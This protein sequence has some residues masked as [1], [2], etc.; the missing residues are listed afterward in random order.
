MSHN[1][2]I[3]FIG[4]GHMGG[5]QVRELIKLPIDVA[6]YDVSPAAMAVFADRAIV[7]TSMADTGRDAD[8]VGI[9]VRDDAQ[10]M[11]CVRELLPVMKAR[12]VIL[13]HSTIR[14]ET[15]A[16]IAEQAAERGVDVLDA[17][18]TRTESAQDGPFVFCMTGGDPD[19]AAGLQDI[20]DAFSTD[21]IHVGP[22]GSAMALKICNNIASWSEILL[23]L[24]V[25][26]IAAKANV[27]IDKLLTV[28]SR[29]GVLSPPMR[30]AIELRNAPRSAKLQESCV[31]L[32]GLGEKDLSL[33]EQLSADGGVQA[34]ITTFMRSIVRSNIL[35]I[36]Q[37]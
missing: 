5:D 35:A 32:G 12:A 22:L 33:G 6:I 11:E 16:I 26:A 15:M 2:K 10:V 19:V 1:R 34:P 3:G 27:P 4:L 7:A 29:N 9:C 14:P 30:S 37:D 18:V 20:L 24:E 25:A 36:A 8:I 28:M 21:T 23:G 31:S 17:P 13:I